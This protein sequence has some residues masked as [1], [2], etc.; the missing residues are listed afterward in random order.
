M[1]KSQGQTFN[2]VVCDLSQCFTSGLGYV[3]LSRVRSI[4][5][6]TLTGF[7]DSALEVSDEAREISAQA[8]KK[9]K[10]GREE[11]KTNIGRYMKDLHL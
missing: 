3:A 7:S 10:E 2:S 6:L 9:A 1:H 5:D 11:F 8:K 4:D